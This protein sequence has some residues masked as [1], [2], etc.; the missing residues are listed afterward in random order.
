MDRTILFLYTAKNRT[1]INALLGAL[2]STP[3]WQKVK[4]VLCEQEEEVPKVLSEIP[5]A[6]LLCFSSMTYEWRKRRAF[7]EGLLSD[8]NLSICGGGPHVT[9]VPED[10]ALPR[11]VLVQGEGEEAFLALTQEFIEGHLNPQVVKAQ[12]VDI[13][14]FPSFP[15]HLGFLGPIE[16]SRGC[17][18]GCAFC[19]TPVLFGKKMRHRSLDSI[20]EHVRGMMRHRKRIDVRF[21]TPNALAYGSEDGVKPNLKAI[22][23]LLTSLRRLLGKEGRIFF[24][25][26]PSEVRP[27]FIS[28]EAL[29]LLQETIDNRTLV[30]GA[31]SGSRRLLRLMRRGHTPEDVLSACTMSLRRGFQV[32]VDFIFGCPE[33]TEEDFLK[34]VRFMQ[35]LIALGAT[36]RAHTFLPLPGTP[37]GEKKP[38]PLPPWGK[39]LLSS[40]A[41][42]GKLKGQWQIQEKMLSEGR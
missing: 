15:Y 8:P 3:L 16:I 30:I 7:L 21:V 5:G 22:D 26:F 9:A 27:E 40:L 4:A 11:T 38:T 42:E 18:F 28:E 19:A 34:T 36:V 31:Q 20:L 39:K 23:I 1:S 41:R 2:S 13:N 10:F 29:A 17:P 25:S 12:R 14:R 33:E 6:K 37:W 32:V 35:E 24:G